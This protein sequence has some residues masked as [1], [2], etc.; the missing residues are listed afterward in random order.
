MD[1]NRRW[2]KQQGLASIEGHRAGVKALKNLVKICP[3]HGIQYLT[4]YAFSTENWKR[5]SQELDFLFSLLGEMAVSELS[6][7]VEENVKVNFIGDIEAFGSG[8]YNKLINLKEKTQNNNGLNLQVA[9]NYGSIDELRRA[10]VKIK[11]TLSKTEIENLNTE[12]FSKYLDST[13]IP[14]PKIL[15][16]SGGEGRLSNY[17]L[18]QAAKAD[19]YFTETLWPGFSE[20]DLIKVLESYKVNL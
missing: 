9:L 2:A 16:R 7:L 13:E 3:K 12:S 5:S 20:A 18:W 1:G 4:V 10:L 14:D 19:L 17:L 8:L 6:N 15:I 11:N